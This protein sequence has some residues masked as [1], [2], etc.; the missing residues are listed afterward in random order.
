MSPNTSAPPF[1]SFNNPNSGAAAQSQDDKDV[2]RVK[3]SFT[4]P[5]LDGMFDQEYDDQ[6]TWSSAHKLKKLR[7][8]SE[9]FRSSPPSGPATALLE[10]LPPS[11]DDEIDNFGIINTVDLSLIHNAAAN[12]LTALEAKKQESI[13]KEITSENCLRR[14]ECTAQ[15][16]GWGKM[17]SSALVSRMKKSQSPST[18]DIEEEQPYAE[19]WI[20]TH[21]NGMS[22]IALESGEKITLLDYVRRSPEQHLG[23]DG[24]TS[25]SDEYDLTF[26]FKVLSINKVLSIQAHPD[27]HLAAQ[28]HTD[29]PKLYKDP[30][31]KP[32][33]AVA[34]TDDFEAMSGFRNVIEIGQHLQDYPE[35]ANLIEAGARNDLLKAAHQK[36]YF[37]P[38]RLFQRVFK[39]YMEA[40]DDVIQSNLTAMLTRLSAKDS[41]ELTSTEELILRLAD[42]FPGDCGIFAPLLFNHLK[43]N[44]GD[45]FYIGANEPH[46]YIQGEILEC[47][48]CSDNVVRAGLTP[49]LKDVDTLVK[50]L[51]YKSTLP[52]ITRGVAVDENCTLFAPPV[53]DFAMEVLTLEKGETYQLQPVLSPSVLLTLDGS[54]TL[55]Q[56]LVQSLD[57]DFGKAAF[58]S[59]NT[60]ATV[61]ATSDEGVKIVRAMSN[62]QLL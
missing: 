1:M 10:S 37:P 4:A 33:M 48:A 42:Q 11:I 40:A 60:M 8:V 38:R 49:K 20:G 22:E 12:A 29:F 16:Y 58:M 46:A 3:G 14:L 34:L 55:V 50:M 51:T 9:T 45:A 2:R 43:L 24:A 30:N 61:T 41:I 15:N 18:F 28:L 57:M 36:Q 44:K 23:V 32:E 59:A 5:N 27:K 47:M 53:K 19:L 25:P 31:H 56:G 7:K 52:N 62:V 54:G 13:Q 35:F 21:P 39:S 6:F 17:G 26:L